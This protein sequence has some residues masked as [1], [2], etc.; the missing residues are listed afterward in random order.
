DVECNSPSVARR[1]ESP[2]VEDDSR[3]TCLYSAANG[4]PSR[5]F[6]LEHGCRELSGDFRIRCR[7][8]NRAV[9][10]GHAAQAQGAC[11]CAECMRQCF[12]FGEVIRLSLN[13]QTCRL[14]DGT[15]QVD[16]CLAA[17]DVASIKRNGFCSC[18]IAG[19]EIRANRHAFRRSAVPLIKIAG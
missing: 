9:K 18:G 4:V 13:L 2:V 6:N 10:C 17:L 7:S 12:D 8:P 16:R 19:V 15:V 1:C 5:S 3:W 11:R 14:A